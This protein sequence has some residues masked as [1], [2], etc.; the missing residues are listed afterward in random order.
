MNDTYLIYEG[1]ILLSMVITFFLSAVETAVITSNPIK[2]KF[3]TE[4]GNRRAARSLHI[5]ENVEHAMGMLQILINIIEIAA[6]AFVAF[7]ATRAFLLRETGL[8]LV[9]AV[10]ALVF[11]T[12]CE[13]LP[14]LIARTRPEAFL[15]AFSYPAH[16]LITV[17]KPLILFSLFFSKKIKDMLNLSER[18]S[19]ISS[20]DDIGLLFRIG[21]KEG[22]IEKG[23]HD[24]I[25]EILTFNKVTAYEVMTPLIDIKSIERRRSIKQVIKLID[26]T[27]FSRIPV[28]SGR[29]DNITGYIHYRDLL[30]KSD[31]KSIDE[32]IKE[33]YFVPS[34]KKI[35]SLFLEMQE[36]QIPIV[37]VV[38]E[39]GA[40]EGM[41]TKEDIAEEIVGEIQTRDH[42]D[43]D[44]IKRIS[45]RRYL[46]D[47]SIDVDFFQK[48]FGVPITKRGFETLAGFVTYQLGRIPDRGDRFEYEKCLFIVEEVTSRSVERITLMLPS[49]GR[50]VE[51]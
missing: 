49:K 16:I 45:G 48:R 6:S 41:V 30:L 43:K 3:Y 37:Y 24:Y 40:V 28:Y 44:L 23:Y 9:I 18:Y 17:F 42:H 2:L 13:V 47:G 22:V 10:Q 31:V 21:V 20:R 50:A 33:P 14:K 38:N 19:F 5:L 4:K 32:I 11:L 46:I 26:E 36:K 35:Y 27:N 25:D 15:M 8:L 7:V 29:V 12:F 34:T 1:A 51:A 39:F